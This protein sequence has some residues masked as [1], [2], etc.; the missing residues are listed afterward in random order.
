M[1]AAGNSPPST[2]LPLSGI[3][4]LSVEQYGAGP[5]STM[6][7]ADLGAEVIKVEDAEGDVAR[8]VPPYTA[9]K[10][11]IYFQSLNRNKKSIQLD[12][13]DGGDR[14]IFEDLV[15]TSQV[16]FNN[17]RG[18]QAA[19]RGLDYAALGKVEPAIVCVHLS[20]FGRHGE[21]AA[22]PAYDYLMQGYTGWMSLTGGPDAPPT[23]SGLSLVDLSAGVFAALGLVSAVRRAESTG[24][25]CDVDVSLYDTA[26]SLLTYVGA[27]HLSRGYHA[28]RVEDSSH[29]SQIPSQIFPTSDGFIVVMCAKEKFYRRLVGL[30]GL[31]ELACDPRFIDFAARLEN[32]QTLVSLLK[33]RFVEQTTADWIKAFTGHVPC[34]PVNDLERAL[35]DEMISNRMIISLTHDTLGEIRQLAS[36]IVVEDGEVSHVRGPRLGEHTRDVIS[37]LRQHVG[38]SAADSPSR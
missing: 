7:L 22:E 16:V 31:P 26:L 11:S 23:K 21:R 15:R 8:Y 28:E 12:L 30:M 25:G 38:A 3:R 6:L 33:A 13:T 27:W 32:K 1:V 37:E 17:L 14:L 29:P 18:D 20:G 24:K 5:F 2:E 10:D 4:I 19:L 36:P 9:E 34:A 35:K